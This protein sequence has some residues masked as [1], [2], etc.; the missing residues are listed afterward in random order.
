MLSKEVMIVSF[1]KRLELWNP[2]LYEKYV[3]HPEDF[4]DAMDRMTLDTEPE[5]LDTV[6][7]DLIGLPTPVT[8]D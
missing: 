1:G 3:G 6:E 2:A 8:E 5:E 7:A 4:N